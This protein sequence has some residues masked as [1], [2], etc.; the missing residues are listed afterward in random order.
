M[1]K[2]FDEVPHHQIL[3]SL[4]SVGVSGPLLDWFKSYLSQ[5]SQKVILNGHS[6]ISL[7][8]TSG[9]PQGSIL[10]SLL[11]IVNINS[12]TEIHLSP[13]TTTIL[14]A[15]D[16]LLYHPLCKQFCNFIFQQDIDLLSNWISPSGLAINPT[17]S[18]LLVISRNRS[19]PKV[20][21][22]INSSPIPSVESVK[23]LGVTITND[24]KWNTHIDTTCK[25]AKQKLGL[26]HRNFRQA[27][28]R[29]RSQLYKALVLPKL[30]YCSCVW[31]PTTSTLT[32]QLESVQRFTAKLCTKDW[33]DPSVSL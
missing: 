25:P 19:K 1:Y 26:L 22:T 33:S 31:H 9:V 11:F 3:R 30:E 23:Y 20:Q 8:V 12:L 2:T 5:R 6:S 16:I 24:L 4:S 10:G 15:E 14:Y 21:V 17:K 18:S 29:T 13:G 28:Q 7:P 32:D 27:D